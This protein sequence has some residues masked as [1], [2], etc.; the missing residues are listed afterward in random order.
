M[1]DARRVQDAAKHLYALFSGRELA[2]LRTIDIRDYIITLKSVVNNDT[3]NLELSVLSSA[4]NCT[5]DAS[6]NWI[7]PTLSRDVC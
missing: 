6:G 1:R 2:T 5:P 4:I 3:I 7:Y